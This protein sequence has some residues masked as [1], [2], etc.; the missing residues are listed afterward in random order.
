MELLEGRSRFVVRM[1]EEEGGDFRRPIGFNPTKREEDE[2]QGPPLDARVLQILLEERQRI[3][4]NDKMTARQ[5]ER[6][7]AENRKTF[8]IATGGRV[9]RTDEV[10]KWVLIFA[11]VLIITQE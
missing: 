2:S 4:D 10:V 6:F 1:E 5:K 7:L 8:T 9:T 11:G 3:Y